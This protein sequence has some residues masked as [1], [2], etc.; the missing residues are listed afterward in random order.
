[1]SVT[2]AFQCPDRETYDA[3]QRELRAHP[4]VRWTL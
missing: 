3:V 4:A 1:V 2:V